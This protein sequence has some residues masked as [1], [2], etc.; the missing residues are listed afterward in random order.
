MGVNKYAACWKMYENE[1]DVDCNEYL[2]HRARHRSRPQPAVVASNPKPRTSLL[3]T[4]TP[5]KHTSLKHSRLGL[6]H[7]RT[8][9]AHHR[10]PL[11]HH[12]T[13][14]AH[15]RTSLLHKQAKHAKLTKLAKLRAL[16]PPAHPRKRAKAKGKARGH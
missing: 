1:E 13:P 14:L 7:H 8:P 10:T 16:P 5:L 11:A 12:R 3:H 2:L 4:R 6:A 9:L 15:P